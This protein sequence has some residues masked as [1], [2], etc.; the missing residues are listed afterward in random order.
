MVLNFI[1]KLMHNE[2][3]YSHDAMHSDCSVLYCLT[4][5]L[6]KEEESKIH[7]QFLCKRS[8]GDPSCL[9]PNLFLDSS[10]S[11][12]WPKLNLNSV[13]PIKCNAVNLD[14]VLTTSL[15]YIL[16]SILHRMLQGCS[17]NASFF[18]GGLKMV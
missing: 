7:I 13:L 9:Q 12:S 18:P 11:A 8:A 10:Q 15:S 6:T 1:V 4:G 17:P 16:C 3:F 2:E 5:W 14:L